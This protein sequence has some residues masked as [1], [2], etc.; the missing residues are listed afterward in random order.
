MF[1]I[2]RVIVLKTLQ[3]VLSQIL[4]I[5]WPVILDVIVCNIQIYH[6]KLCVLLLL[7]STVLLATTFNL[8]Y[9][10]YLKFVSYCALMQAP[11]PLHRDNPSSYSRLWLCS[12]ADS[13]VALRRR[14][15]STRT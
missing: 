3:Y 14:V 6:T 4:Q 5:Q 1:G 8:S 13:Q 10:L 15:A 11:N 7:V 9:L 12:Q 2:D